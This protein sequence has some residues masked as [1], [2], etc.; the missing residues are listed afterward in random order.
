[1]KKVFITLCIVLGFVCT[2]FAAENTDD[3]LTITYKSDSWKMKASEF[4]ALVNAASECDIIRQAELDKTVI[5]EVDD[6]PFKVI[7]GTDYK[8]VIHIKWIGR[9]KKI[10]KQVDI[11]TKLVVKKEPYSGAYI[12]YRDIAGIGFPIMIGVVVLLILL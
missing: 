5:V 2:S 9:D 3:E 7:T 6:A 11:N 12:F 10:I 4:E 1:M 8:T